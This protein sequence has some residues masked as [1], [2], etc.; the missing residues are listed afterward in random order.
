MKTITLLVALL[1]AGFGNLIGQQLEEG[2]MN[3][4]F[5][6]PETSVEEMQLRTVNWMET[7]FNN[8]GNKITS[9]EI[10]GNQLNYEVEVTTGSKVF[11]AVFEYEYKEN[12]C[13]FSISKLSDQSEEVINFLKVIQQRTPYVLKSKLPEDAKAEA[14]QILNK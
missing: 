5:Q 8:P 4:T 12:E 7:F 14:R 1:L 11:T 13:A 10:K 9:M 6:V 2:T 3:S